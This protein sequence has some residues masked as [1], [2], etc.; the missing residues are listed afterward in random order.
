M[1][2]EFFFFLEFLNYETML[3]SIL[4]NQRMLC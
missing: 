2:M 4:V 1:N 3:N